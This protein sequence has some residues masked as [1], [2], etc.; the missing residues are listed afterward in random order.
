MS[1]EW[2]RLI[3]QANALGVDI[4]ADTDPWG[5]DNW[6]WAFQLPGSTERYFVM[7]VNAEDASVVKVRE[8]DPSDEEIE[9]L[10]NFLQ[11]TPH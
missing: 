5:D 8:F 7:D 4:F 2:E 1:K 3:E 11:G 9:D 6:G 10:R